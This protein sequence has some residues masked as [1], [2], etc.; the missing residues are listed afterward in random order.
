MPQFFTPSPHDYYDDV[1]QWR[2]Q[3]GV[4]SILT[5]QK[6]KN[7]Q[8]WRYD[9]DT[10]VRVWTPLIDNLNSSGVL[11]PLTSGGRP[12]NKQLWR[13]D[14]VPDPPWQAPPW[15]LSNAD[16]A[17]LPTKTNPFFR[18]WRYDLDTDVKA[19][20]PPKL[21]SYAASYA[22]NYVMRAPFYTQRGAEFPPWQ[23]PNFWENADALY[24]PKP[25]VSVLQQH[26]FWKAQYLYD[27]PPWVGTPQSSLA[28]FELVEGGTP[29]NKLWRWDF[30][31]QPG[32]YWQGTKANVLFDFVAGGEPFSKLWR[33]DNVPQ[34]DW[35]G[36]PYGISQP[37]RNVTPT[38]FYKLWRYDLDSDVRVWNARP[39]G[40]TQNQLAAQTNP[41]FRL[42]RWDNVPDSVW[43]G[44]P[45]PGYTL[46][47]P[48]PSQNP[49]FNTRQFNYVSQPEW[50]G[51]PS[52]SLSVRLPPAVTPKPFHQLW[53]YDY[54]PASEWVGHQVGSAVIFLPPQ[55]ANQLLRNVIL[56]T[57]ELVN[58]IERERELRNVILRSRVLVFGGP[59]YH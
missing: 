29:F 42:W 17:N 38:P 4:L 27:P 59:T 50:V 32:W 24:L 9:L 36:S 16:T 30:V 2:A 31:E 53:R 21:G 13:Y 33:W 15:M 11:T 34:P 22:S 49:F 46:T 8:L 57:R 40:A 54:V 18:L 6:P 44:T 10:D 41:F 14:P 35:L 47:Q 28:L 52:G 55:V 43:V 58:E 45:I 56:R 20:A 7:K 12:K 3:R 37:L 1:W 5:A 23:F 25:T 19:W 51:S 26:N 48:T 39:T